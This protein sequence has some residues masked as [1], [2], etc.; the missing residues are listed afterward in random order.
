MQRR[1]IAVIVG[2]LVLPIWIALLIISVP[3]DIIHHIL[4]GAVEG[5]N[6]ITA[7]LKSWV[8]DGER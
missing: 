5:L 7:N 1:G 6:K 8:E 3:V 4:E 2:L